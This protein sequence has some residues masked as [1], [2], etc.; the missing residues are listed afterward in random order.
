M[1]SCC[2]SSAE[3]VP[4][5]SKKAEV[6]APPSVEDPAAVPPPAPEEPKEQ[7]APVAN[8]RSAEKPPGGD[9][10]CFVFLTPDNT[11]RSVSFTKTPL[12]MTFYMMKPL[13]VK[14][15]RE[16]GAA[17][18]QGVEQG[19]AL[20]KV[21]GESMAEKSVEDIKNLISRLSSQLGS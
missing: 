3:D 6:M 17:A 1:F 18:S 7:I 20:H 16:D 9:A 13:K 19:W 11:E 2:G 10:L 15:V 21:N 12:G 5:T 4:G 8:V 14:L